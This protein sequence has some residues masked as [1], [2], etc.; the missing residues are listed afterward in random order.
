MSD[1]TPQELMVAVASRE[2]HDGDLVF[3]GMRLPILAYAVARNAHAPSARGLFEV[4][5]MRDQPA[6]GFLGTMGDPPNVSGA[7]W[8][9]RMSNTMALMA[10][11]HVDLGFIGGAEVDRYGNLNTSY[12]G[13]P[14]SPKVKLP[15]SGGGADIA[16]LSRRWVT[17]MSHERRRLV[18]RVS[19]VTSPGHG[20][21]TPGWRS[22]MGLLGGGPVAIITTLCTLRF[23]GGGGE[24]HV[25]SVH[26]GHTVDEVIAETGWP[27]QIS[28]DV[29]ETSAPTDEELTSIRRFDPNGFWTRS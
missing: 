2:I 14:A 23:P 3:V 1:Y 21:G 10:Q 7:L 29:S 4:G 17:L 12:V 22:R 9:T 13:D 11:G 18:E 28:D 6:S 25:A 20:D 15:G 8:A 26:P 16:I 19:F 24:A 5:L 27:L